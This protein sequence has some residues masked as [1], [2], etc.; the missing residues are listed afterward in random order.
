MSEPRPTVTDEMIRAAVQSVAEKMMTGDVESAVEAICRQYQH[1]MD[2]FDLAMNLKQW[3]YWDV[4]RNEMEDLDA[5]ENRIS[6]AL[7]EAEKQWFSANPVEPPFPIGTKTTRGV[8]TGIYEY[9]PAC[10][11]VQ[12]PGQPDN[13]KLIVKFEDAKEPTE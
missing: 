13:R 3:E 1:P 11:L 12:E 2:G 9:G 8:I 6:E 4:T 7:R 5:I 10:Y